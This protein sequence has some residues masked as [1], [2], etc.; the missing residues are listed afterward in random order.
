MKLRETY[1][2][3]F[4]S[5][6]F[7][8]LCAA[9][10]DSL[11]ANEHLI[12]TSCRI[13]LPYTNFHLLPDNIVAQQ[14]WGKIKLEGAFALFYFAKGGKVQNLMHRFKYK[15]QKEIGNLLGEIAGAQLIKN[16]IYKNVDHIIPVPL[17]KKRLSQ[18]GYNQSACFAEGLAKQ[19]NTTVMEHN[20][21]R[22]AATETQ[23][24][25][26]RF[27][28]YQNMKEVFYVL[29]PEE[30]KNKHILLVDDVITTG[31]TLEACG[32]QLLRIEGLKLS[33]ATIA[34]AE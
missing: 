15:G 16:D 23:T 19:L 6:L 18:R 21:I 17:H 29:N 32:A 13:T 2:A 30:L 1:I 5:L 22:P 34:Y 4:V 20:L 8:E 26:S 10:G 31:S 28:R 3:D 9:C 7:P 27:D 33:I 12:C 14:F 11:V 24:R 25:K